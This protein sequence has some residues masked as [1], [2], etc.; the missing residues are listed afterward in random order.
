MQTTALG[1]DTRYSAKLISYVNDSR[2]LGAG[3]WYNPMVTIPLSKHPGGRSIKYGVVR[4][5]RLLEDLIGWTD[6][7]GAGRLQKP[8]SIIK[9]SP[10]AQLAM[11]SNR[12]NAVRVALLLLPERFTEVELFCE[13][14]ALSYKGDVR[15]AVGGENPKKILNLVGPNLSAY[16]LIYSE[17]IE[18]FRAGSFGMTE[19]G[20]SNGVIT[21]EKRGLIS[22][23][24]LLSLPCHLQSKIGGL[25]SDSNSKLQP[26]HVRSAISGAIGSIVRRSSVSQSIKGGFSAG[27]SRIYREVI[28]SYF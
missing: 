1:L 2:S 24:L 12:E 9:G 19:I 15:L 28:K 14:A 11:V 17:I 21:Y 25:G 7:Y 23:E 27:N 10:D 16:R 20:S 6:L 22:R 18:R 8:V 13:I 4:Y 5:D 26:S 3:Y